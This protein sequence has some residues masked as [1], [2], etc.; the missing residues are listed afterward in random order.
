MKLFLVSR[1]R[2]TSFTMRKLRSRNNNALPLFEKSMREVYVHTLK[3]TL[4]AITAFAVLGAVAATTLSAQAPTPDQGKAAPAAKKVKDQGEYDIFNEALKDA[5]TPQ[6]EIADLD[7]WTQKYPDSDYKWDRLYMYMQAYGKMSPPQPQKL[8]EYGTKLMGQDMKKIFTGP[9]GPL[10]VLDVLYKVATSVPALPNP[11]PEQ[12][13]LGKKA[14]QELKTEADAYFVPANKPAS[15]SDAAWTKAKG[16][17]ESAADHSLLAL[18]LMPASQAMARKDCAT[19]EPLY[20]KALQDHPTSAFI[21]Y[22]LANAMVCLQTKDPSMVPKA[23][24]EFQR[25]AVIDPTL[26]DPANDPKKLTTYADSLYTRVHGSDEG[27]AQ[28]KETA[29]QNPLPPDGFVIKTKEQVA[30]EKDAEFAKS[31][32]KLALWNGIKTALTAPDGEQ[33]FADKLKDSAVPQLR[34]LLVEGKPACRS[35]ELLVYV[36]G[37]SQTGPQPAEITIKL[38]TA[39]S[40]KP[41]AGSEVLWEGVPTAFTK[42]PF[43]LTMDAEKA[44]VEVKTTPCAAPAR[45]GAPAKK[46]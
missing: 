16:D 41:E 42:S 1:A 29:K 19:A 20:V 22:Q 34:G 5:A 43:M 14:A 39:L 3:R 40:G 9:N 32:P 8:V 17:L 46:K 30:A 36:P 23:I 38:D 35:K 44:K 25:A 31:N 27:L 21:S 33:Y 45:K 24:Y 37:E 12:I 18:E 11:T 13:D 10:T 6:K 28:L 4:W 15:T 2:S 26:G 7:T